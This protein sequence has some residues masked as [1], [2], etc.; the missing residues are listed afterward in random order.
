[1]VFKL[2]AALLKDDKKE[3]TPSPVLK[4]APKFSMG[5]SKELLEQ[6]DA[7]R[8]LPTASTKTVDDPSF[9]GIDLKL[10]FKKYMCFVGLMTVRTL[11]AEYKKPDYITD[12]E[13][14]YMI[15]LEK[16]SETHWDDKTSKYLF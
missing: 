6:L 15:A 8:K 14:Q 3:E 10:V 12:L 11:L 9:E 13:W 2:P 1:M 5:P 7:I 4:P 16:E